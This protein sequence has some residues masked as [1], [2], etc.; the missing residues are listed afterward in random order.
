MNTLTH[1]YKHAPH[2]HTDSFTLTHSHSHSH[3]HTHTHTH[4]LT[5]A[6]RDIYS[7][8]MYVYLRL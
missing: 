8:K 2:S 1:I 4:T 5:H 7:I 3:S 6:Q